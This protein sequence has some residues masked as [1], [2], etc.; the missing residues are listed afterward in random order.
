MTKNHNK[1]SDPSNKKSNSP[2]IHNRLA[3]IHN[4]LT[5]NKNRLASSK[6]RTTWTV[7]A[8][9]ALQTMWLVCLRTKKEY[10]SNKIPNYLRPFSWQKRKNK[11]ISHLRPKNTK[12]HSRAPLTGSQKQESMYSLR[13]S[14]RLSHSTSLR[15]SLRSRK[16]RKIS[17]L[18]VPKFI[19]VDSVFSHNIFTILQG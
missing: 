6:N 8:G 7:Q 10:S 17:L 15:K 9:L 18:T 1:S 5:S 14:L 12:I 11:N 4:R 3:S 16:P 13:R 2:S 19:L